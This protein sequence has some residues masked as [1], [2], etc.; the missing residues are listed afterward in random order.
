MKRIYI[1]VDD[2]LIIHSPENTNYYEKT[3]DL[4]TCKI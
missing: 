2:T 4:Q 1:Y 3:K